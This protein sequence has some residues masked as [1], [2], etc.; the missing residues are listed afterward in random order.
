MKWDLR[1][2]SSLHTVDHFHKWQIL[3]E[4]EACMLFS[5]NKQKNEQTQYKVN[6]GFI[7]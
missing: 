5:Q 3:H 6:Y 7:Y 4:I 2:V 1:F